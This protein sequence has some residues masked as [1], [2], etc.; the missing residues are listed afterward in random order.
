VAQQRDA[1]AAEILPPLL[2]A[3]S[4]FDSEALVH[5]DEGK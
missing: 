4:M 2:I 5:Q 1:R 3:T